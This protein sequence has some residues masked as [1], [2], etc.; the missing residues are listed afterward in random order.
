MKSPDPLITW[1]CKVTKN[2]VA[3]VSLLPQ[4]LVY[5]KKLQSIKSHNPFNM[6]SRD[7]LRTFYL[8]YHNT[9]CHQTWQVHNIQWHMSH[10]LS[11]MTLWS[12]GLPILISFI[13][14]FAGLQSKCVSHHQLLPSVILDQFEFH[15]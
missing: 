6:W 9:Y 12:P 10:K 5:C 3:A 14:R 15:V 8:H 1:S 4:V 2:I 7:E 11:C 13:L